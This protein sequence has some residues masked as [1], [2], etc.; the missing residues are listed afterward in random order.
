VVLEG[1]P[2][3]GFRKTCHGAFAGP[4]VAA[5]SM[6]SSPE[7]LSRQLERSMRIVVGGQ[8]RDCG[9][10]STGRNEHSLVSVVP[11]RATGC[12]MQRESGD[13]SQAVRLGL[14]G[15]RPHLFFRNL[16]WRGS[17]NTH[18]RDTEPQRKLK[19]GGWPL[20]FALYS[21][22]LRIS[23]HVARKNSYRSR[24]SEASARHP[25]AIYE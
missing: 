1:E 21:P 18:H 9:L 20:K 24:F 11:T 15:F 7:G 6:S 13:V 22:M 23:K 2:L 16:F 4:G 5:S 14:A 10:Q 19:A 3:E 8:T 25:Q 12:L 17:T